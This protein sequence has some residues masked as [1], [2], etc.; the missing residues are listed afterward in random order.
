[1]VEDPV[2]VCT[3]LVSSNL[4]R[5]FGNGAT[6]TG[7]FRGGSWGTAL[8]VDITKQRKLGTRPESHDFPVNRFSVLQ[9]HYETLFQS[10]ITLTNDRQP[11]AIGAASVDKYDVVA[12]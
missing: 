8:N 2:P 9:W 1:M 7:D 5:A 3:I 10:V 11:L 12:T 4:T 6:I